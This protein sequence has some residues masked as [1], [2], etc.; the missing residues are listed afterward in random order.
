M[1][2]MAN[3]TRYQTNQEKKWIHSTQLFPMK[4][5]ASTPPPKKNP[6]KRTNKRKQEK[7]TTAAHADLCEAPRWGSRNQKNILEKRLNMIDY[8]IYVTLCYCII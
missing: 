5:M 1:N 4:P 2:E 3:Q 7:G 6:K 8:A